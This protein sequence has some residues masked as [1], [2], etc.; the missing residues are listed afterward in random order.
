[1]AM[2]SFDWEPS[3]AVAGSY[4][5]QAERKGSLSATTIKQV[6][7]HLSQAEKLDEGP[8]SKRAVIAQLDNAIRKAGNSDPA[9]AE[10]LQELRATYS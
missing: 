7:Q 8:A 3:F 2:R 1:M 5:D 10:A 9:V 4:V 6:R